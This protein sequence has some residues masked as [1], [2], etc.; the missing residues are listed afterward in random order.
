[1]VPMIS[2]NS[3]SVRADVPDEGAELEGRDGSSGTG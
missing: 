3:Q 2:L 1:M